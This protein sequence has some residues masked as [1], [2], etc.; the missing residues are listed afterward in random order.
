[1]P[2][3]FLRSL[4]PILVDSIRMC[5][6]LILLVVIFAPLE[7]FWACAGKILSQGVWH[8]PDLLFQWTRLPGYC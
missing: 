4:P 2:I 5:A 3:Q 7:R 8:R 1:M 6:W